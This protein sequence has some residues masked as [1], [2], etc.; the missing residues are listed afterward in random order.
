MI[1]V[2]QLEFT[3]EQQEYITSVLNSDVKKNT[4]EMYQTLIGRDPELKSEFD[5]RHF[6]QDIISISKDIKDRQSEL[7]ADIISKNGLIQNTINEINSL[8]ENGEESDIKEITNMIDN[9][10]QLIQNINTDIE[11]T[12]VA[13]QLNKATIEFTEDLID[14]AKLMSDMSK[15]AYDKILNDYGVDINTRI[16]TNNI[17]PYNGEDSHR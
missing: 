14:T 13:Y 7:L 4:I 3:K 11:E 16:D 17:R 10:M 6:I 2:D 15:A 9:L 8:M 1:S 5:N 12:V